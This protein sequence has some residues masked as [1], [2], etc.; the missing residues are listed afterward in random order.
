[1]EDHGLG[2]GCLHGGVRPFAT[3]GEGSEEAAGPGWIV[4]LD[5]ALERVED[6]LRRQVRSIGELHT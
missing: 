4:D 3:G 5:V 2:I 1:M 6:V